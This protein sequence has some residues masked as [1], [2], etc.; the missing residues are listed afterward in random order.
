M[1]Y[2]RV[3][4]PPTDLTIVDATRRPNRLFDTETATLQRRFRTACERYRRC[5]PGVRLA[6]DGAFAYLPG[7]HTRRRSATRGEKSR[8]FPFRALERGFCLR[9]RTGRRNIWNGAS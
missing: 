6:F 8:A 9:R 4:S 1:R 2:G 7:H 3:G 5:R